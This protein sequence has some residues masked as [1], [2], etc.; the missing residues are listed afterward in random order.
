MTALRL[1]IGLAVV[2]LILLT[3]VAVLTSPTIGYALSLGLA[4]AALVLTHGGRRGTARDAVRTPRPRP[5][6]LWVF[7]WMWLTASPGVALLFKSNLYLYS[8][9][10]VVMAVA[11]VLVL[12]ANAAIR[13]QPATRRVPTVAT[14][15]VLVIIVAAQSLVQTPLHLGARSL[16]AWGSLVG[17]A[18]QIVFVLIAVRYAP[19]PTNLFRD[20]TVGVVIGVT[21]T[22]ALL[23]LVG[24]AG[25]VRF[26]DAEVLHPNTLG[27]LGAIGFLSTLTAGRLTGRLT[28]LLGL[29][30]LPAA[31]VLSL[32]K[33]SLIA[34]AVSI[35]V[36]LVISNRQ[37]RAYRT[38][39]ISSAVLVASYLVGNDVRDYFL[40]YFTDAQRVETLSDRTV[41]WNETLE[42]SVE[43]PIR[44]FGFATFPDA[45][46]ARDNL[47]WS[48]YRIAHAH[49]AYLTVLLEQ[50]YIGLGLFVALIILCVVLLFRVWHREGRSQDVLAGTAILVF[51]LVRSST[52]GALA[53]RGDFAYLCAVALMLEAR[54]A[55]TRNEA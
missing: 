32:S 33:T 38:L 47:G 48:V 3:T 16:A 39:L 27:G 8:A 44:G 46:A 53:M 51:L 17:I 15:L 30:A 5:Y 31:M 35:A 40:W 13:A 34:C 4:G 50:G 20:M 6:V 45:L 25:A 11:L 29:T 10:N 55:R 54:L 9:A 52:E 14:L 42:R 37:H 49:N 19:G 41:L 24:G 28:R 1:H 2:V 7:F 43:R 36:W 22:T 18:G 23:V 21:A 12:V 26:G